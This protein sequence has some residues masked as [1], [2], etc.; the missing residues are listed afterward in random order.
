MR[1][2]KL[3]PIEFLRAAGVPMAVSTDCNPGTAPIT[4]LLTTLNMA[5][6]LFKMTP[7]EALLGA[8]T[9]AAQALGLAHEIGSIAVGKR[10]DLLKWR[11][12]HPRDLVCGIQA[13]MLLGNV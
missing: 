6:V 13:G 10:A 3:P 12:N 2:T 5:T 7:A 8:T 9:H 4:S 1:E 11:I